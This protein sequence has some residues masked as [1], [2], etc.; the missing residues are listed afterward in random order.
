MS[1]VC[2]K[3]TGSRSFLGGFRCSVGGRGF[4]HGQFWQREVKRAAFAQFTLDPY[5]PSM[6]L[7]HAFHDGQADTLPFVITQQ[8]LE[9]LETFLEI[10]RFDPYPVVTG[11]EHMLGL[12]GVGI[13]LLVV[14]SLDDRVL[15]LTAWEIWL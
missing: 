5:P 3:A 1:N 4:G 11:I 6:P 12:T 9:Q 14:T 8:A 7:H 15:Y 10:L 13:G 2:G